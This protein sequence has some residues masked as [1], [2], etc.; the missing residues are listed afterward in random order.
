[1]QFK[2]TRPQRLTQYLYRWT[3]DDGTTATGETVD[4][5]FMRPALR[6]VRLEV[7]LGDELLAQV[8]HD[9]YVHCAWDKCLKDSSNIDFFDKVIRERNLDK[10]PVDDLINLSTLAER[11]YRPDWK[12]LATAAL[13]KN[14]HRLVQESDNTDFSLDF[15]QYLHSAELKKYDK[16]LEL[17]SRLQKKSSVSKSVHR[18]AMI[19]QAEILI[20]YFGRSQEALKIVKQLQ[21]D[22]ASRDAFTRRGTMTKARAMLALGQ[23]KEAIELV[24]QLSESLKPANKVNQQVKHSGLM[25]H[26]RLLAESRGDPNRLDYAMAN[27]ETI[28]AEDPVKI[29]TPSVNLIKLDIHLARKEFQAAFHLTE[30]L[31]QLQLNDYDR[32]QTLTRQVIALCGMRDMEKAKS[33][34]AQLNRDYPHSPAIEEAKD[35]IVQTL[36][37]Q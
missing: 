8:A 34:Y 24:Q 6:K 10:A 16:A 33:V 3:F 11:A 30:R 5:V 36:G 7:S 29:F 31:K 14:L 1:M 18:K 15:G 25:R 26:A 23:A 9:V 28:V 21:F 37:R 32:A 4:H 20:K 22:S 12:D 13:T 35:A 2:A 27:I 19:C 17:F